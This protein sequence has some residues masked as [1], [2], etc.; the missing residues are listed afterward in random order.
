MTRYLHEDTNDVYDSDSDEWFRFPDRDAAVEFTELD[1]S[2]DQRIEVAASPSIS[3]FNIPIAV[4]GVDL[5]LNAAV[6]LLT[7]DPGRIK[8]HLLYIDGIGNA[9]VLIGP[10][11]TVMAG[12]GQGYALKNGTPLELTT[13][14]EVWCKL[15]TATSSGLGTMYVLTENIT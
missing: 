3:A 5:T 12:L 7:A 9:T 14:A 15:I 2:H 4:G 11:G 1:A 6:Q 8:A 10:K 13:S